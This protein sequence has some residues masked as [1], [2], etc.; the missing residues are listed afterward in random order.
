LLTGVTALCEMCRQ[1]GVVVPNEW[2]E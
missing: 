1:I 2:A